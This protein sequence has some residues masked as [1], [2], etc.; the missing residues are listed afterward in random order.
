MIVLHVADAQ[1]RNGPTRWV[2]RVGDLWHSRI[3]G[4]TPASS[5]VGYAAP[6]LDALLDKYAGCTWVPVCKRRR[7]C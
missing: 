2:W 3:P 7:A 4:K 6:S 1:R 5:Y